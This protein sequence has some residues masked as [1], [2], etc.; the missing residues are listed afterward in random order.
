MYIKSL[1]TK[2][3]G[4]NKHSTL[5]NIDRKQNTEHQPFVVLIQELNDHFQRRD[6]VE[7]KSFTFV[8]VL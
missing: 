1:L 6:V 7:V 8:D 2:N 5:S 3:D 4:Q